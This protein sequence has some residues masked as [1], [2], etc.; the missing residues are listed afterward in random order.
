MIMIAYDMM[1]QSSLHMSMTAR[2]PPQVTMVDRVPAA[3]L[4]QETCA[5]LS[6]DWTVPE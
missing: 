3:T 2:K 1:V 6:D 5:Y 4:L